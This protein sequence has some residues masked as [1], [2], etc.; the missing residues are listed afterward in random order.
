M[1]TINSK[2]SE[3]LKKD[4][5]NAKEEILKFHK[6]KIEEKEAQ[7]VDKSK[8]VFAVENLNN[9]HFEVANDNKTAKKRIYD[10][11]GI[12]TKYKIEFDGRIKEIAI[13]I[14]KTFS[15]FIMMGLAK[16]GTPSENGLHYQK[17]AWMISLYSGKVFREEKVVGALSNFQRPKTGDIVTLGIDTKNHSMYI[18]VDG[19]K[20]SEVKIHINSEPN[21]YLCFD[22]AHPDDMITL[23]DI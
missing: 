5:M 15:S 3:E 16:D 13:K 12:F 8:L 17:D 18:K 10:I 22:L 9:Q 14:E 2:Q 4:Y 11:I 19:L 6:Q 1:I 7:T 23:M 20:S 21:M